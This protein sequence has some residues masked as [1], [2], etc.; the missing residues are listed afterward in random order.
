[1]FEMKDLGELHFSLGME[2]E[3]N[4]DERLLHINQIKYVKEILKHYEWRNVSPLEFH[5]IPK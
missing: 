2:L 4:H 1:M 5:S 3:R